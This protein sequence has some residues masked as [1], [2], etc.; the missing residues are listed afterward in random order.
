MRLGWRDVMWLFAGIFRRE[1]IPPRVRIRECHVHGCFMP[2]MRT[3]VLCE[4]HEKRELLDY[5]H[6]VHG[7]VQP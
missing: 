2:A 7:W 6:P 1:P 5:Y 3:G 4:E